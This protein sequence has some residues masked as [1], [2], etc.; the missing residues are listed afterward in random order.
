[1]RTLSLTRW[2][3]VG[4]E[5]FTPAKQIL[6]PV[7]SGLL[8]DDEADAAIRVLLSLQSERSPGFERSHIRCVCNDVQSMSYLRFFY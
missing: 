1:M 4:G 8:H 7:E 5:N 6:D 3:P 2:M